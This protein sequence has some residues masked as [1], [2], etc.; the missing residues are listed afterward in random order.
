[1]EIAEKVKW[2]REEGVTRILFAD[3]VPITQVSPLVDPES[4]VALEG[5]IELT[6]LTLS[7]SDESTPQ[8]HD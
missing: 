8:R 3:P 5:A 2:F 6:V 1:M 4:L 7:Q